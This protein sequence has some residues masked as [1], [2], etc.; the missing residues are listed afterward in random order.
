MPPSQTALSIIPLSL[1]PFERAPKMHFFDQ[2]GP[3]REF[4]AL[5]RQ[6]QSPVALVPTMGALHPGH[7]ALIQAARAECAL[8][9]ATIFVN[10][11]QFNNP[12][13]LAK[14]PRTLERDKAMLEAA[15]CHAI[16]A[17]A[18]SEMYSISSI[19]NIQWKGLDDILE[20]HYRPGHF[21]GVSLV[22]AK[23]FNLVRPDVA[24]FGQKDFQQ[25]KV[26]SRLVD[27]LMFDIQLRCVE[28]VREADGLAMSSRNQRL[29]EVQRA[30]ALVFYRTLQ[31]AR[32]ELQR[33][34]N[35][36]E[37]R[38]RVAQNFSGARGTSME[39]LELADREN[40]TLIDRVIEPDSGVLLIAGYVGE[41]R[42][43]DNL[44][45]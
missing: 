35:M 43:I 4:L 39:Y 38:K 45:V 11:T 2:I 21:S 34:K 19:V 14:Y 3:F 44:F 17:P 29:N 30:D 33:G 32:A 23:L 12:E 28:T 16:F 36:D 20:G 40:L 7:L 22:V 8:V 26:I 6:A 18:A 24:Y 1:R 37:I 5:A 42:L 15:G 25:F 31:Q 27:E 41:V 9:I 10:P 13:D